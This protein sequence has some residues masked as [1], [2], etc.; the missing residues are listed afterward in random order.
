MH[1]WKLPHSVCLR[2]SG[3]RKCETAT[4]QYYPLVVC[5]VVTECQQRAGLTWRLSHSCRI[6]ARNTWGQ[7]VS[8][9]QVRLC[10]WPDWIKPMN[11]LFSRNWVVCFHGY[12]MSQSL[13]PFH[14]CCIKKHWK[15]NTWHSSF[16]IW[17]MTHWQKY[18]GQWPSQNRE[19][20][21]LLC[22]SWG[23][24]AVLLLETW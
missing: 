17:V 12:R 9:C 4:R 22:S 16:H 11:V 10:C 19:G 6:C 5:E 2:I 3:E 14:D 15:I 24:A 18:F 20:C 23:S 7:H 21:V 1:V 13:P 8:C